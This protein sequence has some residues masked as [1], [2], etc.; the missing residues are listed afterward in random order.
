MSGLMNSQESYAVANPL[1]M[2]KWAV[3]HMVWRLPKPGQDWRVLD[4]K[5]TQN[6][7]NKPEI[8]HFWRCRKMRRSPE[9]P[10]PASP[11]Q[12]LALFGVGG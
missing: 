9:V 6:R 3:G 7:P 12:L 5:T 8:A 11:P 1:I 4:A 10:Q 2:T